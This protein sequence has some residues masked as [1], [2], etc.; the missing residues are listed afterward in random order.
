MS[1]AELDLEQLLEDLVRIDSRNP[2]LAADSPGEEPLNDALDALLSG[3]G[4]RVTREPVLPG[5]DNLVAVLPGV[6]SSATVVFEAHLDTVPADAAV[7]EVRRE[8]RRLFG[9]GTCDTKASLAAMIGAIQ[10]I[11]STA[12]PRPTVILAAACDEEYIMRG[13]AALART[14]PPADLVVVG[15]PTS[16]RPARAH[17]GLIR[18]AVTVVGRAAHSSKAELGINAIAQASELVLALDA[19][20]GKLRRETRHPLTG[21]ALLSATLIEGGTAPNV[22][23]DRCVVWFDRRV[24]P[25]EDPRVA[26]EE[27]RTVIRQVADARSITV[28]VDEP[29]I[30]LGGLETAADSI[31]VR[32]AEAAAS[33][34]L[35]TDVVASG[36]TFA[37]D[38]CCF[39][40]R[41]D[42]PAVVL[43]PGSI[44]QAHTDSEW[45]DLDEVLAARDLYAD[46][47]RTVHELRSEETARAS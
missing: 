36:V 39:F 7:R 38:A 8:G 19:T 45:V 26:M 32:A 33:R 22:V 18:F 6:D 1:A 10:R 5:R 4:L 40:E 23:P 47:A 44:D 11:A 46:L 21:S 41:P 28:V 29:I 35:G 43:G 12:G 34:A 31:A 15:E 42:L 2:S 37:T 30:A 27:I 20:V 14:L 3:M 9:R 24:A 16:L 25:D 17:N 13:G